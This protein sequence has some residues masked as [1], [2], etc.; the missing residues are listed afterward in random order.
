MDKAEKRASGGLRLFFLL[1]LFDFGVTALG[2]RGRDGWLVCLLLGIG[3]A[4]AFA[5]LSALCARHPLPEAGGRRTAMLGVVVAAVCVPICAGVLRELPRFLQYSSL[6]DAAR[7][8]ELL[9]CG[10]LVW[11][12]TAA[13]PSTLGQA[14]WL[15]WPPAAALLLATLAVGRGQAALS[16]LRP[17]LAEGLGGLRRTAARPFWALLPM[18]LALPELSSEARRPGRAAAAAQLVCFAA[19]A[20][21]CVRD[22]AVLGPVLTARLDDPAFY[23]A[24]VLEPGGYPRQLEVLTASAWL[25]ALPFRAALPLRTARRLLEPLLR[26][27]R[28]GAAALLTAGAVLLAFAWK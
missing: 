24:S 26:D 14:G 12:L 11:A 28:K 21:L 5:A 6:R 9:L 3:S 15:C 1:G 16:A 10:V 23:A 2:V 13:E 8:Q 27:S 22:T 20:V 4:A 7:W 19:A 18:A 25:I 17:L